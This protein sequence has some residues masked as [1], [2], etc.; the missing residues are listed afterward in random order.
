[1]L[2]MNSSNAAYTIL[3]RTIS[4]VLLITLRHQKLLKRLNIKCYSSL[5]QYCCSGPTTCALSLHLA[6]PHCVNLQ[7]TGW[8]VFWRYLH[9][10]QSLNV[11][12]YTQDIKWHLGLSMETW[13]RRYKW[14]TSIMS[15]TQMRKRKGR[16][17]ENKSQ[18]FTIC[19]IF[20]WPHSWVPINNIPIDMWE[21]VCL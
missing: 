1:M 11:A 17:R 10:A 2:T 13:F 7:S 4:I 14:I 6:N 20:L 8:R 12:G 16:M 21:S 15:H 5:T 3:C 18:T 19:R 9:S